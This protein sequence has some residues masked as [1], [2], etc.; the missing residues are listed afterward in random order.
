MTW[1][2]WAQALG[3]LGLFLFSMRYLSGVLN[4]AI[5]RRFKPLLAR[6]LANPSRSLGL[7]VLA[8][9]GVQASAVTIIAAMGLLET[10][11][12]NFEQAFYLM[13]G[14]TLG[15]TIKLWFWGLRWGVV[16]P[17]LLGLASLALV[18][19]RKATRRSFL[20]A[21]MALG[22][23]YVGLDLLAQGLA[24]LTHSQEFLIWLRSFEAKS[25]PGQLLVAAV[26]AW[27][28]MALQSS[29]SFLLLVFELAGLGLL[30]L[31]T[32]VA[33][34]LGANL[35]TTATPVLA[36]VE[37]E[38]GVQRLAFSHV[39]VKAVGVSWG[40]L[41]FPFGLAANQRLA[42]W[43]GWGGTVS[44]LA[45]FHTSFNFLNVA[46]WVGLAPLYLG[47]LR[48][49]WPEEGLSAGLLPWGVRRLLANAPERA[50][51]EVDRLVHGLASEA[52]ALVDGCFE[53]LAGGGAAGAGSSA[54]A[55]DVA[56]RRAFDEAKDAVYDLLATLAGGKASGGQAER[57]RTRLLQVGAIAYLGERAVLLS[58]HLEQGRQLGG[59][60]VPPEVSSALGPVRQLADRMWM[61][62][63]F[64]AQGMP[65]G[66]TS[67]AEMQEAVAQLE[68]AFFANLAQHGGL[69]SDQ[70]TW[71]LDG[72]TL[73]RG[74]LEAL[75]ALLI[76]THRVASRAAT[77]PL[78]SGGSLSPSSSAGDAP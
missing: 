32:S 38:R 77:G 70:S 57:V 11:L 22:F 45:I 66:P 2:D 68:A 48:K 50:L 3:G 47:V 64:G 7:G 43:F 61:G 17:L 20:E 56:R 63:H 13:L 33:L 28:T 44:V 35:G 6:L 51:Q 12:L 52:Q 78:P 67:S 71:V 76:V 73:S 18:V 75:H 46:I 34:L 54:L 39:V 23:T 55:A 10:G 59:F 36:A 9:V 24:P 49:L 4:R 5:A 1:G 58:S 19:E 74:L 21:V 29:S 69:K 27:L 8:T 16:G 72:L 26:G 65:E 60:E 62:V 25:L 40:L 37:H 42:E 15:T 31:N 14:S 30:S 41:F 53:L